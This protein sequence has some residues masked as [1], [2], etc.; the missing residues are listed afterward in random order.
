MIALPF[1]LACAASGAVSHWRGQMFLDTLAIVKAGDTLR[2]EGATRIQARTRDAGILV[3]GTLVVAGDDSSRVEWNGGKGIEI[4]SGASAYFAGYVQTDAADGLH[5]AGGE[6]TVWESSLQA[7]PGQA[8]AKLSSGTLVVAGSRLAGRSPALVG[9]QGVLELDDVVLRAD[10]L[11]S[12]DPAVVAR[13]QDVDASDGVQIGQNLTLRKPRS[14][15]KKSG[16]KVRWAVGPSFGTRVGNQEDRRD[17]VAIPLR[18]SMDLTP[19]ITANLLGGWRAGWLGDASTFNGRDQTL[20]RLQAR[21]LPF[22]ELGLEAGYG[23]DPIDWD[24][25]KAEM[26]VALLDRSMDLDEPFVAP[27]PL[28]GARASLHGTVFGTA[29]AAMGLGY[30]WRGRSEATEL[31][32]V[33]ATWGSISSAD[34]GRRTELASSAVWC[35]PDR[36]RGVDGADRW[37]WSVVLDHRRNLSNREWGVDLS[38]EGLDGGIFAQRLYGDLLWGGPSMRYGPVFSSLLTEVDGG[39][40]IATGPGVRWRYL[41][42]PNLRI[43]LGG[44]VRVHRDVAKETW[45]GGDCLARISGGF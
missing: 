32:D 6:A 18:L 33:L 45:L 1:V 13:L 41:P 16:P 30:Q 27:G 19:R 14:S 35:L 29:Q 9:H 43:D 42:S 4:S 21:I 12:L 38:V 26:A 11:W 24:R 10:T 22:L 39:W 40:G 44:F 25:S 36:I 28:A 20:A 31:G 17:V 23:G 8:A 5:V 2:I 3:R 7:S 15:N 37:Q 34:A